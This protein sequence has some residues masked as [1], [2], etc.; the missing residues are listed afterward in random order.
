MNFSRGFLRFAAVCALLTAGTTV[1]VHWLPAFWAGATTFEAQLALRENPVYL[2]RLWLVLLHCVLVVISMYAVGFRRL[3]EAPALVGLGFLAYVVFAFCEIV[4]TTF[5][6]FA[7]NRMWRTQF[8]GAADEQTRETARL[9]LAAVPGVSQTLFFIFFTA[10][11]IGTFCYGFVLLRGS[12]FER[13]LGFFFL[14]WG[15]FSLPVLVDE[16]SGA[17]SFGGAFEWVGQYFQPLLR[18]AIGVWL[19]TVAARPDRLGSH[20]SAP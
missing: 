2:A 14:A 9:L 8:A 17:T 16:I 12:G 11:V 18:G 3:R 5:A 15:V 13:T 1:A 20:A 7:V 10:F 19:W 4:R 6:I